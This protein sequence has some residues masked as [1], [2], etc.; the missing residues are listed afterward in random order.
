MLK[1]FNLRLLILLLLVKLCHVQGFIDVP[2][3]R[4]DFCSQLLF[5]SVE[6]EPVV[7]GDQVD[8]NTKVA[9]PATSADPVEVSLGHLWEVKVDDNINGLNVNPPGEQ[10]T[11]DQVTTETRSEVVEDP[12][13]VSLSHLG[14]DVVAGVAQLGDLLG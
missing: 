6:G 13:A 8:C 12:V 11:A 2:W 7:V 14:V 5:N 9:E 3:N 1:F 10:V 4:S